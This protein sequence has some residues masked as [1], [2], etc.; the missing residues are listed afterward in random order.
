MKILLFVCF[1]FLSLFV[2]AEEKTLIGRCSFDPQTSQSNNG[3]FRPGNAMANFY[4]VANDQDRK[5]IVKEGISKIG[6]FITETTDIVDGIKIDQGEQWSQYEVS[7]SRHG[8]PFAA[9]WIDME[10]NSANPGNPQ[11][12][13]IKYDYPKLNA[14]R[15]VA[16][17]GSFLQNVVVGVSNAYP[18]CIFWM[19]P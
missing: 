12:S 5:I 18:N 8:V 2:Q 3:N 6:G 16:A 19:A 4:S 15:S 10:A 13:I 11:K 7:L 9:S 14:V 17:S 1:T